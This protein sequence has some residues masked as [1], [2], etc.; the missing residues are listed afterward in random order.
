[1]QQSVGIYVCVKEHGYVVRITRLALVQRHRVAC[2]PWF[3]GNQLQIVRRHK[4][5]RF[6]VVARCVV[7]ICD[8]IAA[9]VGHVL[10]G[11][12]TEQL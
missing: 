6:A 4:S 12:T 1:M 5:H 8:R 9:V 10:V 2:F 7:V 3:P 11:S